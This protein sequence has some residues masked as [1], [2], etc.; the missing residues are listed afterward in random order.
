MTL[1][2]VNPG[3]LIA[4]EDWNTLVGMLNALDAR[5]SELEQGGSK[6]TPTIT[7]VLPTGAVMEGD[8]IRIY[9]ANFGFSQ[10]AHSVF[11][12]NTRA[13]GFLNGSSD[14]LLIVQVPEPVDGATEAGTSLTLSVGNLYGF[15]TR[16]LTV[17]AK[18]VSTTG[19]FQFT[20]KGSQPTT[21]TQNSQVFYD[22][23]LKS[24]ANKDLILTI[25]PIIQVILP[26]PAGV[27]DPGLANLLTVI[28]AD[29]SP[30]ADH[31]IA[32]AEGQTKTISLRL[33]LPDQTNNLRYS[34][35]VTAGA[36]GVSPVVE[37]LPNQQVGQAGEQPDAT[38][39]VFEFSAIDSG[40][41]QF[42]T[43][44]GGVGGVDGTLAVKQG[45]TITIVMRTGFVNIPAGITNSYQLTTTP[46]LQA[47]A[48]GWSAS[49]HPLTQNPLLI[50]SPGG[51]V[52]TLFNIT[53]PAAANT[54]IL[55]L[56]LTRQGVVTGNK[57]AVS[58][59]LITTP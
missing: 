25:T 33:N 40:Q 26:L 42:S 22:F 17:K 53:A 2:N 58:Y 37:S 49:V 36:A 21:P 6:G 12:G 19:G 3:D 30:R 1:K 23:E 20:Y 47:P 44:T 8:Q 18:P 27:S 24:F 48:N 15:T 43:D 54:A 29:G 39:N 45:T 56:M 13:T 9:G 28:D 35:S 41:G 38:V 14:S 57:R 31:L 11:F 34:L 59:R 51:S 50:Q 46:S 16:S 10:G 55:Q 4:S 32:L 7:Q 52:D 5:V